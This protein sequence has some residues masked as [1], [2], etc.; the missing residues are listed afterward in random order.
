MSSERLREPSSASH[1]LRRCVGR[2]GGVLILGLPNVLSLKGMRG[3]KQLACVSMFGLGARCQEQPTCGSA[4]TRAIEDFPKTVDQARGAAG[5]C[6]EARVVNGGIFWFYDGLTVGLQEKGGF[7][8]CAAWAPGRFTSS[9]PPKLIWAQTEIVAIMKKGDLDNHDRNALAA[10]SS[11]HLLTAHTDRLSA[12]YDSPPTGLT[13]ASA[14]R[15]RIGLSTPPRRSR[16]AR[17]PFCDASVEMFLGELAEDIDCG[18]ALPSA[19]YARSR[20]AG[21]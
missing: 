17:E 5:V 14:A 10:T 9:Y 11:G 20:R 15:C 16:D 21:K 2:P 1:T 3:Q 7:H 19:P 8:P 12:D 18:A 6:A 13:P 4:G